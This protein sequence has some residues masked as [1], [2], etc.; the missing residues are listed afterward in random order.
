[1]IKLLQQLEAKVMS[2]EPGDHGL[3]LFLLS[4]STSRGALEC[5]PVSTLGTTQ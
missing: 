5:I 2:N 1:M 3:L 4:S